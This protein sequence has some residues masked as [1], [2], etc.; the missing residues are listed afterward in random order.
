MSSAGATGKDTSIF[1]TEIS[2]NN[3]ANN[4]PGSNMSAT[5][6][7]ISDRFHKNNIFHNH[8]LGLDCKPL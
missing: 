2:Q 7:D 5:M 4:S 6:D 1:L 8:G 3:P